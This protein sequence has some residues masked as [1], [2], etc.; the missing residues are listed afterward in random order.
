M[1]TKH[2]HSLNIPAKQPP[3]LT[4]LPLPLLLPTLSTYRHRAI[5]KMM[6]VSLLTWKKPSTMISCSTVA[7]PSTGILAATTWMIPLDS[8]VM[9][10][11]GERTGSLINRLTGHG[12]FVF[13][14][15]PTHL[16]SML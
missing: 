14:N 8:A 6:T 16:I 10:E 4:L 15:I 3:L 12:P 5:M 11:T 1:L 2:L 9:M 7:I 13:Q